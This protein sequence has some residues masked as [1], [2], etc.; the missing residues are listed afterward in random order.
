[1]ADYNKVGLLTLRGER[2]LLCRKKHTTAKLILPG[3]CLEPGESPMECLARELQEELGPVAVEDLE[4]VGLYADRAATD[5]PAVVKTVQIELYRGQLA[6]EPQAASEI[7]ELVWF[8][9]E[10]DPAQLAPSLVN[11]IIPDLLAR[12]ILPWLDEV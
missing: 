6:G 4:Y 11:K 9:P 5:D 1:M 10:D 2:M 7:K 8:G 3:G 12:H